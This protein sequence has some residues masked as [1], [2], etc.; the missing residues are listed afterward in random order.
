MRTIEMSAEK[1]EAL[2]LSKKEASRRC[3]ARAKSIAKGELLTPELAIRSLQSTCLKLENFKITTG[4][5]SIR[6]NKNGGEKVAL[7]ISELV[8][9]ETIK[10]RKSYKSITDA[11]HAFNELVKE[12]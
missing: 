5:K 3:R 1:L 2:R 9:S 4:T 12:I 11:V 8:G 6:L 7:I 10:T